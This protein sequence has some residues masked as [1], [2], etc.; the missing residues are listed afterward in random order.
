MVM[1]TSLSFFVFLFVLTGY[2]QQKNEVIRDTLIFKYNEKYL[3]RFGP[4]YESWYKIK[5]P[6]INEQNVIY[7]SEFKD[8]DSIKVIDAKEINKYFDQKKYKDLEGNFSR[9]YFYLDNK[10][11]DVFLIKNNQIRQIIFFHT[12]E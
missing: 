9:W 3:K 10:P 12:I 4:E 2:S 8:I 6:F 5:L 1:K 11:K 7:I